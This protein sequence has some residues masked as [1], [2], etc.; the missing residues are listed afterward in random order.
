MYRNSQVKGFKS[1]I[2][3]Q[4]QSTSS[5]SKESS[6]NDSKTFETL[7][8]SSRRSTTSILNL[9]KKP[10]E[11]DDKPVSKESKP[12]KSNE[13][14]AID[15]QENLS[16]VINNNKTIYNVVMAKKS[17]R[18][19]KKWEDDGILEITGKC[20]ILKDSEGN[21][22]HRTTVKPEIIVEGFRLYI[23][24]KEV[25]IVDKVT[26]SQLLPKKSVAETVP[27]EPPMKKL[28]TLQSGPY[29]PLASLKKGLQL[30]SKPLVM[31]SIYTSKN[32][33]E[34]DTS[35]KEVEVSVDACLA[36]ALRPHQRY[37]V[38]FLYEC[39]MGLKLPNYFG[40][41]LADE[42]GLG[43]TL[44]CITIIWTLLKKGPYGKPILK[45]VLIVTPSSL[46]NN[47][48]KEFSHWLGFHRIFPYIVNAKNKPKDFRKQSRNSVMIISYDMLIRCETEIEQISFDLI[49]CD[50]GHRLKNSD[51]KA[52][53][54]LNNISCKKRILLSGTPI[55][56]DLQEFFALIDF[57]NPGVLGNHYEFKQY[58]ENPIVASQC[59]NA[60]KSVLSLGTERA[61]ELHDKTKC[62]ILRR[63]QDTINKYLPSK[64]ELVVFCRLSDE[65]E[66]LYVR[67]TDAWFDKSGL[68]ISTMPHLTIITMLK[69]ICN[70]PDLFYSEKNDLLL[71]DL[72]NVKRND[73]KK[74]Y[75]NI[76]KKAYSGK[77]SVVQSL[78][79]NLKETKEKLVLV[80]YYTQTLDLLETVCN[81]EN[82]HFLRLDGST[83]SNSRSKIIQQFNSET[84]ESKVFLLSAK[85]GG[86]GLNLPGASRLVLFDSDWNPASDAQAMARIWREGQKKNVYILRLLTTGTIE[87]KIFQRQ[88]SKA[89]L[90]ETVVDLNNFASLKLSMSELK[91]L[92]TL[93]SNT[94]CLTHDLI[95]CPCKGYKEVEK[96]SE[97]CDNENSREHQLVLE[98]KV[99]Q[100]NLAINQLLEWEHYQ[101]PIPD[102]IMQELLLSEVSD[103]ITF[104]FK[105]ST[106]NDIC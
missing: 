1:V 92:F 37:G 35:E 76:L 17:T 25:E 49:V 52:A 26:N 62:F 100:Q 47:W 104:L 39:I 73:Y 74:G 69:K 83:A 79:K 14:P 68:P 78:M 86:V 5:G 51:I 65:Q 85:A 24:N 81:S 22:I 45:Y 61:G 38:V 19:H 32:W 82:L 30:T 67:V 8:Q 36:N 89:S 80:S 57:V 53:K 12:I 34:N 6:E 9:F 97:K 56:N 59:P 55:Q 3:C 2:K 29:V 98:D 41:I 71:N 46:C 60:T 84:H 88:I 93:A 4:Q 70:H 95:K 63:T 103:N 7:N 54:I 87:E 90:S 75:D 28:K 44:Q 102:K 106:L 48:N 58:Y 94:N 43:K 16:S 33:S 77:I 105:N 31:P 10:I 18:K 15:T 11:K 72:T 66:N 21:I 20:G 23:E 40:A 50:E 101:Q 27:S 96:R 99:A 64:H 13:E 42:M 91:D